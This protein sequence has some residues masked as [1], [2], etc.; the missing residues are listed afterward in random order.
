MGLTIGTRPAERPDCEADQA[1]EAD[2]DCESTKEDDTG[3]PAREFFQVSWV[4]CD[5][6]GACD[7]PATIPAR[8]LSSIHSVI[9]IT[10]RKA[11]RQRAAEKVSTQ[12]AAAPT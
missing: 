8:G 5:F 3:C 6:H 10:A 4:P 12:P 7:L 1:H 11:E 2:P 9:A